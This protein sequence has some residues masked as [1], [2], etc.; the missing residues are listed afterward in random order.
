MNK[1]EILNM[2]ADRDTD[3]AIADKIFGLIPCVGGPRHYSTD[4][5]AAWEVVDEMERR[6]YYL[7]AGS[8]PSYTYAMFAK[9]D[10]NQ[11]SERVEAN[12]HALPLA[13][14]RAALLTIMK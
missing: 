7:V 2:R 6:N 10:G 8:L 11:Y 1:D 14:C 5:K 12:V 13:I 4:I 9:A 3:S